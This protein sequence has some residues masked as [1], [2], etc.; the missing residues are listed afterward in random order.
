MVS[1]RL[2]G[3]HISSLVFFCK[4]SPT[5]NTIHFGRSTIHK[6]YFSQK[7]HFSTLSLLLSCTTFVSF[8]CCVEKE[9]HEWIQWN[10][11]ERCVEDIE[12]SKTFFCSTD[13][14]TFYHV[15]FE[16]FV[17]FFL[18]TLPQFAP[19]WKKNRTPDECVLCDLHI[20]FRRSPERWKM[21]NKT[22]QSWG[23]Q[24]SFFVFLSFSPFCLISVSVF[25]AIRQ[26]PLS[27]YTVLP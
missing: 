18:L 1:E 15:H 25:I 2:A 21:E 7:S 20:S 24:I 5:Q 27:C 4:Y 16:F 17:P 9:I 22:E 19:V 14:S 10:A 6:S 3:E 23:C 26:F 13:R 11:T 12:Y 8:S